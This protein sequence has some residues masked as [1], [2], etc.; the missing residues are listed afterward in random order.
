MIIILNFLFLTRSDGRSCPVS[1]VALLIGMVVRVHLIHLVH[2]L[3]VLFLLVMVDVV[4]MLHLLHCRRVQD[5][6]LGA[7]I[8]RGHR[9]AGAGVVIVVTQGHYY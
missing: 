9:E 5:D 8:G 4:K 2:F 6:Q 1:L 3:L 7:D